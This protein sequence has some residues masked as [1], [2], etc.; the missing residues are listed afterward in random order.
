VLR[1]T[2]HFS[3]LSLPTLAF[4]LIACTA[5]TTAPPT[6]RPLTE[7][8]PEASLPPATAATA[9]A[10][11]PGEVAAP[12]ISAEDPLRF[13]FPTLGPQPVSGW[14]P[15]QVPVP[16]SL[17]PED[18]FWF[19][20]P[21]AADRVNWPHPFYRYGSTYFGL[22]TI[23][24]GVDLDSP[25]GTPVYAAGPGVVV[26]T[27]Y[28]LYGSDPPEED[29]YGLAVSIRQDFGY[30]GQVLYTLY[31][32]LSKIH[33]WVDQKVEAGDLLGEVGETGNVTGP[34]LHFEVRVGEN[35]YRST[36]NPEL[37][38]APPT[39]WGVLA[40]R[41]LDRADAPIP[42]AEIHVISRDTGREW[43]IFSYEELF[44]NPDDLY[45][46]NFALSDLPAGRYFL[47]AAIAETTI[48]GEFEILPGRTTFVVL[49][50]SDGMIIEPPVLQ[51][52]TL[53][54]YSTPTPTVTP[55]ATATR[56][57]PTATAVTP[58]ATVP[59]GTAPASGTP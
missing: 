25:V 28:G 48:S 12:T 54:P 10:T 35:R 41:L 20:R 50:T 34:H 17:R 9:T 31:G 43:I 2:H 8:P 29:P 44:V 18:H 14:R 3:R 52:A 40:G 6:L 36:R 13:V 53:V 45:R 27:G 46:E 47:S 55:T 4:A 21:I 49:S 7:P 57:T 16:L 15:P 11:L 5:R 59:G 51:P 56:N 22:M 23:H 32:H 39:G 30:R 37:W 19:A 42:A 24:A 26:W 33:V 38:L 58:D 1:I